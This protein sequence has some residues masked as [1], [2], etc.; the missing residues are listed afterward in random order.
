MVSRGEFSLV[1]AALAA[2]GTGPVMREVIP[3]FAVGY[4]LA[5]SILGTSLMQDSA[6]FE[7]LL[8]GRGSSADDAS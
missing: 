7:R 3:A 5:M 2:S 1:I 6:P 4:V 8:L